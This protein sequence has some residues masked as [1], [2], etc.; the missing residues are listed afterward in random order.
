MSQVKLE[1]TTIDKEIC[2]EYQCLLVVP[3]GRGVNGWNE[4]NEQLSGI[5]RFIIELKR[6]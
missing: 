4:F 2:M 6:K 3:S 5:K 1:I